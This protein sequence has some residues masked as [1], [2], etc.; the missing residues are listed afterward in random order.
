MNAVL[1]FPE[2]PRQPDRKTE[3][4][5]SFRPKP[6]L[7]TFNVE[8][9]KKLLGTAQRVAGALNRLLPYIDSHRE[10]AARIGVETIG[11]ELSSER[12]ELSNV[13]DAL[14]EAV[15]KNDSVQL[16]QSGLELLRRAEKLV[17]EAD[18]NLSRFGKRPASLGSPAS[19]DLLLP[20]LFV[21]MIALGLAVIVFSPRE[22][23]A[24]RSGS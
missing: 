14:E 12:A 7:S 16:S 4:V 22:T 2:P 1:R 21:G 17:A 9:S 18:Q 23:D 19:P 13:Q 20:V 11:I 6:V 24:K 3:L 8:E 5:F 15:Q 10:E